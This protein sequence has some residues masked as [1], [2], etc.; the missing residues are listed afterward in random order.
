MS[1]HCQQMKWK[2]SLALAA[3]VIVLVAGDIDAQ[4]QSIELS[5]YRIAVQ[6]QSDVPLARSQSIRWQEELIR[7]V[8]KHGGSAWKVLGVTA[9]VNDPKDNSANEYADPVD[10]YFI[11]RLSIRGN[12]SVVRVTMQDT[13]VGPGATQQTEVLVPAETTLAWAT[14]RGI[15]ATFGNRAQLID[16][17]DQSLGLRVYGERIPISQPSLKPLPQGSFGRLVCAG[18]RNPSAVFARVTRQSDGTAHCSVYSSA[19]HVP[20]DQWSKGREVWLVEQRSTGSG[21][22]IQ[23]KNEQ[24]PL[25]G[26]E[27]AGVALAETDSHT[28]RFGV[29]SDDG[30]IRV[31]PKREPIWLQLR[32]SD[33]VIWQRPC[34]VGA[35]AEIE[36]ELNLNSGQWT[37]IED[38]G[39]Y[40]LAIRSHQ[41]E[42]AAV[43][44]RANRLIS[45]DRANEAK[46]LSQA[47]A[48]RRQVLAQ[49]CRPRIQ[50]ILSMDW[51]S[52]SSESVQAQ[53]RSML[54]Q[55]DQWQK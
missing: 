21:T 36:V 47:A 53:C 37:A 2:R 3:V 7:L 34:L 38:L 33:F 49:T 45:A 27:V 31:P 26:V 43:V 41:V 20:L 29:T 13:V 6:L 51:P 54:S 46:S 55:L 10:K 9:A 4:G 40:H 32:V 50:A 48:A 15:L 11:C 25:A 39:R 14:W 42:S 24:R 44:H 35:V 30:V 18:D 1:N 8:E 22:S 23:V 16:S 12:L 28:Y 52:E 17:D 19:P 5:P